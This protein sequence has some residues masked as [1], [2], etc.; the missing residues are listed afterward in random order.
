MLHIRVG[1]PLNNLLDLESRRSQGTC[2]VLGTEEVEVHRHRLSPP[3]IEMHRLMADVKAE[4]Q[5]TAR[6]E[7]PLHPSQGS[8]DLRSRDIWII[9]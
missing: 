1:F 9:K 8:G 2:H 7:T 6:T 3:F 4:K 5:Q